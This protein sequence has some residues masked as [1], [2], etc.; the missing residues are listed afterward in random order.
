MTIIDNREPND[1]V[2]DIDYGNAFFWNGNFYIRT[3]C[4]EMENHI[5]I[6]ATNLKTGELEQINHYADVQQVKAKVI[7]D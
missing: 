2:V 5:C 3:L 4:E 6:C 1:M 7:F